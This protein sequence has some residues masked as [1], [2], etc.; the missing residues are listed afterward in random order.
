MKTQKPVPAVI[1][2]H[3]KDHRYDGEDLISLSPT[4]FQEGL[5]L[6]EPRELRRDP[7]NSEFLELTCTFVDQDA[8]RKWLTFP[9]V[10]K[11]FFPIFKKHLRA[12]PKIVRY[13]DV[14]YDCEKQRVCACEDWPSFLLS[15]DFGHF[16]SVICGECLCPIP[17]YKIEDIWVTSWESVYENVYLIW[18]N[19]G[20]LECWAES[21]LQ[22]YKSDLNRE[23]R[24]IIGRLHKFRPVPAYY[25]IHIDSEEYSHDMPCPNCGRKGR[26]S[27]W[28][29][30]ARV[31]GTCKL[32]FGY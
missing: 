8:A 6:S 21:Q 32:A 19:S 12:K 25:Q 11:L 10:R 27:P 14:I 17:P 1:R 29:K 7:K 23:A 2:M 30:P 28:R 26:L 13:R 22:D 15:P 5:I 3:L 20:L 24:R 31:C 9:R 4:M 16:S 18:L